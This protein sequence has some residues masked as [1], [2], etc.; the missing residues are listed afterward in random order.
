PH[1]G[2]KLW[3]ARA[4]DLH[5]F[6][7]RLQSFASISY[8]ERKYGGP[9]PLFLLERHDRQWDLSLGAF[10][11]LDGSWFF[12]PALTY[13]ESKSNIEV[14]KYRRTAAIVSLRYGF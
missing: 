3:G 5:F 12:Q 11:K 8:E 6:T 1:L 4:A 14:F 9:D 2:H 7:S 10:Y 13:T